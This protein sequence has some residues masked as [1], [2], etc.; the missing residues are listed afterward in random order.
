MLECVIYC[1]VSSKEQKDEG[2]SLDVQEEMCED[3]AIKN[4]L[5]IQKSW[6]VD[7]SASK[8]GRKHFN[9]MLAYAQKNSVE[10]ILIV[11][12]SRL[13]RNK[14]DE[15]KVDELVEQG[16]SFHF[17]SDGTIIS[18]DVDEI[19]RL[20]QDF[21]NLLSR[22]EVGQLKVRVLRSM[23]K[24]L[25]D[26]V[27]PGLAPIGYINVPD[28]KGRERRIE[29][30]NEAPVVKKFLEIFSTGKY[31]TTEMVDMARKI[32]LKSKNGNPL[33]L[34]SVKY[35]LKNRFYCGEWEWSY[36]TATKKI[37][38]KEATEV[39]K[40]KAN[41]QW[42]PIVSKAVIDKN[43]MLMKK[44]SLKYKKSKGRD[45]RYKGLI[46]CSECG[47]S[48]I[49]SAIA[50]SYKIKSTGELKNYQPR[51]YYRCNPSDCPMPS[52]TE[53]LV[54]SEIL[55]NIGYLEF[56]E[57]VW[58]RLRKD[59]FEMDT[60]EMLSRERKV[61]NTEKTK[62]EGMED[63]L[64]D[65]LV[66]NVVDKPFY[67]RKIKDVR[68]RREE[69]INRLE[70]LEVELELWTEGVEKVVNMID[71]LKD[72]KGKFQKANNTTKQHMIKLM[73]NR[74][75]ARSYT[76]PNP[77]VDRKL[78]RTLE[79]E[80]NDEF[81]ALFEM[82]IIKKLDKEAK[83]WTDKHG[84][85]SPPGSKPGTDFPDGPLLPEDAPLPDDL[86]RQKKG[87][88]HLFPGVIQKGACPLFSIITSYF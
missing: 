62:V 21:K 24:K 10:H 11:D 37:K 19:K 29:Q 86:L 31:T 46:W 40:G 61:L 33:G 1:R 68:D 6:V 84:P 39:Y 57:E 55:R 25:K 79:F 76:G 52:F 13:H 12:A 50:S 8:P 56:D 35:I 2:I 53:D 27:Y 30:T 22:Y 51:I 4:G 36:K 16:F 70:E 3:Y 45:F 71:S 20:M 54:E 81:S 78:S 72:F 38:H 87:Y 34:P 83:E 14:K 41:G 48:F 15:T 75:I 26:G 73:T 64:Y 32:G 66:D 85:K 44:F 49:G 77:K 88:R 74:I 47:G 63:R 60:K 67:T 23:K 65:D 5:A 18:D 69:I 7:E 42:E 80:W 9:E 43:I 28:S 58:K 82:G 59:L 17:V